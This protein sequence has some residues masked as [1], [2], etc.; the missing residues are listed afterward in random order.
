MAAQAVKT[1]IMHTVVVVEAVATLEVAVVVLLDLA[2]AEAD[3]ITL[4]T[5]HQRH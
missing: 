2:V 4:L 3:T 5:V 1:P